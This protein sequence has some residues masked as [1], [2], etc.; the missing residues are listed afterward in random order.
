MLS[1]VLL[2]VL[3][4]VPN[5]LDGLGSDADVAGFGVGDGDFSVGSFGGF[6]CFVGVTFHCVSFSRSGLA[7]GEDSR[8]VPLNNP[9]DHL[10]DFKHI[11]HILLLHIRLYHLIK[12][13]VLRFLIPLHIIDLSHPTPLT[14]LPY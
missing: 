8:V 2:F 5:F 11:K 6:V 1:F 4:L 13:I 9:S 7:I 14:H 10:L 12:L 3:D